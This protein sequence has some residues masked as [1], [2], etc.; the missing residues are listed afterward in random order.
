M[1]TLIIIQRAAAHICHPNR[2]SDIGN[3]K[4]LSIVVERSAAHVENAFGSTIP[5]STTHN[6]IGI[7]CIDVPNRDG[8]TAQ[9]KCTVGTRRL[10]DMKF[11]SAAFEAAGTHKYKSVG[12]SEERRVGKECRS[13]WSP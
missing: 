8:S 5:K 3:G 6:K 7:P 10:A 11:P 1:D 9:V 12:R 2:A 4:L 13:R